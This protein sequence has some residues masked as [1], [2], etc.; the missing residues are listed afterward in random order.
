MNIPYRTRY[1]LKRAA[2]VL[3][4]VLIAAA[5]I[6]TCWFVWLKRYVVYT[7]D[8]GAIL[9]MELSAQIPDGEEALPPAEQETVNI[10]YNEGDNAINTSKELTQL[11]GYYVDT[12]ALQAGIAE[13][14]A[15]IKLQSVDV[16]IML[17]VKSPRGNFYY[18]S[19]VSGNRDSK[20]D[21]AAMDALISQLSSSGRYLIARLPALRDR[22]YGLHNVSDGVFDS[23][24]AYLFQDDGGCYWLNPSRQ[25]TITY[26]VQIITE[27]KNLGFDEVVFD[28]FCFPDTKYKSFKGDETE[29]LAT[30]AKT[31]VTTCATD[32][33]AVSFVQQAGFALPDGR[34]RL[35]MQSAA[36]A[37][38]A[39]LA[40][41]SGIADTAVRLVFLTEN[42]DT[43]FDAYSVLRP[44]D[45]A[46]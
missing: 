12:A 13:V 11:T 23:R 15:Q 16:P 5:L 2:I 43:R 26:L 22:D 20:V 32:R 18:S 6:F 35:Y 21:I 14:Q 1:A 4:I 19:T 10:F 42:H 41:Q 36:A 8:N 30:A 40:Q 46:H 17:D 25:G 3:L 44:L 27:L 34:S 38:A 24:G 28:D 29:A 37:D 45:A 7:R 9:N 39:I 31:L 33:F